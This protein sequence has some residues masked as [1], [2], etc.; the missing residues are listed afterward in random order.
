MIY[1]CFAFFNELDVLE[2]RLNILNDVVDQ[3]VIVEANKTFTGK[4]KPFIFEN[5]KD[6][7]LKFLSKIKY[8]KIDFPDALKT[9]WE[10]DYYQKDQLSRGL[11]GARPEDWVIMSDLDE[12]P[13]PAAIMR[14]R[15]EN[16]ATVF[17]QRMFFYFLNNEHRKKWCGP[18]MLQYKNFKKLGSIKKVRDIAV[19]YEALRHDRRFPYFLKT[20]IELL[21]FKATCGFP[22][23][24]EKN[25]GWHFSYMGGIEKIQEK[26]YAW[27]HTEFAGKADDKKKV[28]YLIRNG[29]N[30]LNQKKELHAISPAADKNFPDLLKGAHYQ[31]LMLYVE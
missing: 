4:P 31:P 29:F 27:A 21:F 14:A 23:A 15:R 2:I 28:E 7:F 22:I 10:R 20:G 26:F 5:N 17:E 9:A 1:D 25:G 8:I 19:R 11:A 16:V 12:I 3:F 13:D 30:L 6:R 18:V 24:I